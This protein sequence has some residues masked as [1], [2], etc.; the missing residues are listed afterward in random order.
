MASAK[1]QVAGLLI[2]SAREH[3]WSAPEPSA[4]ALAQLLPADQVV[5]AATYHRV[6]GC[7]T[8]SLGDARVPDA[9]RTALGAAARR[10]S[11]QAVLAAASLRTVR[12][13][14]DDTLPWLAVK[15][16]VLDAALYPRPRLRTYRDLDVLVAPGR[17]AEAV[18]RLEDAGFRLADRNWR[19]IRERMVSQLHLERE[20]SAPVDLHWTL[21]F[22]EDRRR[23]FRFDLAAMTARARS[24]E[25][26]GGP[27]RTF[28]PPDTLIHLALHAAIEG[29][30][31][32]VWLK[33]VD[34]AARAIA[35]WDDVVE[36]TAAF[37]MQLPVAAVLARS[38]RVLGAPVPTEVL[39]DLAPRSWRVLTA[40]VDRW[41]PVATSHGVGSP[42]TLLTRSA[43]GRVS[44]SL[45]TAALGLV[46]RSRT[47]LAEG[48]VARVDRRFDPDNEGSLLHSAGDDA[49]RDAYFARL[50]AM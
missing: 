43:R 5:A 48:Q 2:A 33:D 10:A 49:D 15:G 18:S 32:L 42:A 26:A 13:V 50:A 37:G 29:G 14:F 46:Q 12:A 9:L 25:V 45:R 1:R 6:V 28:D 17:L 41:F 39:A 16:P 21:L 34:V 3:D 47:T 38:R 20:G 11:G 44:T 19:Q 35:H 4:V 22:D 36:R 40:A 23:R 31:R 30:D 24:V 8:A 7:V 27:V